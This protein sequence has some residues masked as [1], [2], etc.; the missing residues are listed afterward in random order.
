MP[1]GVAPDAASAGL[2]G[3]ALDAALDAAPDA[4]PDA[5]ACA[6]PGVVRAATHSSRL[7]PRTVAASHWTIAWLPK[8]GTRTKAV[9]RAPPT[10]P[11]V[12]T[13]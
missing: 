5:A 3:T 1:P 11:R 4:G 12:E 8:A 10:L 6:A 2:P 9:A 13:P 7:A